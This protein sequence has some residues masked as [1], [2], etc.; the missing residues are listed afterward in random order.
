MKRQIIAGA[1]SLALMLSVLFSLS[2]CSAAQVV[3]LMAGVKVNAASNDIDLT[4]DDSEAIAG[5]AV[6]L[7]Q[8]TV[9]PDGNLLISPLSVLCALAMTA[10]GAEDQTLAQM[11]DVIG[12]SVQ[13]LNEYLHAYLE[14]LPAGDKYKVSL[15]NSIWF[16]DDDR[17]TVEQDFLQAN[18]D[19]YG[20][21]VYKTAFDNATL[22]DINDW[23]SDNTDGM[24]EDILDEIPDG[25]V[26]YLINALAFDAEWQNIYKES[27]VHE[28]T[29]TTESGE[30]RNVEMMYGS[31]HLYLED[32]NATGFI[33]YYAG[34]KYAFAAL[35]P[36]EGILLG[37]YIASLTGAGFM[38][39]LQNAR[40][41][42]VNTAI[43]KFESEYSVEMSDILN[44]MGMT[45]AFD[46]GLADFTGLGVWEDGN[47]FINR[48]I[49]KTYIAVDEKGTRA[50]AAT[51]VEMFAGSAPAEESKT[52]YLDRPFVYMLIDSETNLPLFIGAVTDIGS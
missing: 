5:F 43:P 30:A 3:D 27:Q 46:A 44:S 1:L 13:D 50:G 4:G 15:A 33:K 11:E 38:S 45:N 40:D 14:S 25:A 8:N 49:H 47:L 17:L 48:V 37:D 51:A 29:F 9:S 19:Y 2:G 18:A 28:G 32:G 26:M 12:L 52:V 21:S 7:F 39:T 6:E 10:N 20:A 16:R 42:Q 24:I 41:V 23:V 22:K 36:N 35:L 31:E 34:R